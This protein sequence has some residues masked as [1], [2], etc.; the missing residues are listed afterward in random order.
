MDHHVWMDNAWRRFL[1]T[2]RAAVPEAG[3]TFI[4]PR[5]LGK[6]L[7]LRI[8][9]LKFQI[10]CPAF[11]TQASTRPSTYSS[12]ET[13]SRRSTSDSM[14]CLLGSWKALRRALCCLSS[15]D[16]IRQSIRKY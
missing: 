8:G 16:V 10:H 11:S 9:H 1:F 2:R 4:L 3:C 12:L 14:G 5:L 6:I 7:Y 15:T 13:L